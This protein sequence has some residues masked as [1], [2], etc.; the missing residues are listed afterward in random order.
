MNLTPLDREFSLLVR[1]KA[2]WTCAR[3]ARLFEGAREELHCSHFWSRVNKSVRF[4]PE[5]CDALCWECHYRFDQHPA[6]HREW[7]LAKM[8]PERFDALSDR[9]RMIVRLDWALVRAT[10]KALRSN[11]AA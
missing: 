9:A 2:G 6:E 11:R 7:K 5:N 4:D 3:C 8:G 10:I 1:E